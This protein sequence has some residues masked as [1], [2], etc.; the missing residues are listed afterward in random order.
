M[1][2]YLKYVGPYPKWRDTLYGSEIVFRQG[3]T[4]CVHKELARRLLRH[5]DLFVEGDPADVWIRRTIDERI[6]TALEE[7]D[8][9]GGEGGTNN[10]NALLNR[11]R[12]NGAV[13]TGS[14]DIPE[15]PDNDLVTLYEAAK[16]NSLLIQFQ[17][18]FS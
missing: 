13:M 11:P 1:K 12:Y 18:Y 5:T 3:R 16:V 10:F 6:E 17:G 14:T 4:R 8:G 7:F 9:G 15:V 2:R